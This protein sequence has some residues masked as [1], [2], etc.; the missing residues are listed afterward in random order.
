MRSSKNA[1]SADSIWLGYQDT[2]SL[3]IYGIYCW[4]D[5]DK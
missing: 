2:F 1:F 3:K 5:I 4:K